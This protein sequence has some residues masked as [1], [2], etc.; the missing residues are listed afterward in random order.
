MAAQGGY[1][2][3]ASQTVR[4][5][6]GFLDAGVNATGW[7]SG[8]SVERDASGSLRPA[9]THER[10][11]AMPGMPR[12]AGG[13]GKKSSRPGVGQLFDGL[14]REDATS[15][16]DQADGVEVRHRVK[17]DSDNNNNFKLD[18]V[19]FHTGSA[20]DPYNT[21]SQDEIPL[22]ALCP[23]NLPTE[24]SE[25]VVSQLTARLDSY[26]QEPYMLVV[27]ASPSNPI[28]VQHLIRYYRGLSSEVRRNV[29]RIWICHA[30]LFT[31]MYVQCETL[32]GTD[33]I[34]LSFPRAVRLFLNTIVSGKVTRKGKVK[35]VD[36][37]NS[38]GQDLDLSR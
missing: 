14:Q 27:F 2:Y 36:S 3:F 33:L 4:T 16:G 15:A 38:L 32:W 37:L 9:E 26:A 10:D 31:K 22:L 29:Q 21:E 8:T 28:P 13:A 34:Q 24:L 17:T 18:R 1:S 7:S 6:R 20:G 5:L 30:G 12:R 19:L 25:L 11:R 35:L 23:C